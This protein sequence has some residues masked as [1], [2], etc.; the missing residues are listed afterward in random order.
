MFK[1]TSCN[2]TPM[3]QLSQ[4]ESQDDHLVTNREDHSISRELSIAPMMDW[5]DHRRFGLPIRWLD[6]RK[7]A[8]HLY[9]S[10]KSWHF[11]EFPG[12]IACFCPT[13][14]G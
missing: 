3:S 1:I 2:S 13:C 6:V 8:C 11:G 5:T 9:V 10:S 7:K 4:V 14:G 12:L